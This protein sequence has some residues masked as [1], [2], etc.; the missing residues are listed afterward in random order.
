LP[1]VDPARA[2]HVRRLYGAD[3]DDQDLFHLHIDSTA[4]PLDPARRANL[5]AD[6]RRRPVTTDPGRCW[7]PAAR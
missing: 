1:E 3:I 6:S 4:L 5:A 2:Q 7:R